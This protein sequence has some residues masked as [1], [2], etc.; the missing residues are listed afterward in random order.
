MIYTEV[1]PP[2]KDAV[3][4]A[5]KDAV[6]DAAITDLALMLTR[7]AALAG[8]R[9]ETLVAQ[10]SDADLAALYRSCA[11]RLRGT[12]GPALQCLVSASGREPRRH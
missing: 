7:A 2:A 12:R 3:E 4:D 6:E 11:K 10:L 8:Q 9:P 1:R 5:A